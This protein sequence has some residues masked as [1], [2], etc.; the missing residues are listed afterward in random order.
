[1][2]PLRQAI[3]AKDLNSPTPVSDSVVDETVVAVFAN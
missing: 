2:A 3:A 1:M